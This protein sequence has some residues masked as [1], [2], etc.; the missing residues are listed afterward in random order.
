[1]SLGGAV[2]LWDWKDWGQYRIEDESG[3]SLTVLEYS[4][5]T[6]RANGS[7]H[8]SFDIQIG[9]AGI[10]VLIGFDKALAILSSGNRGG[11]KF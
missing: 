2:L 4:Q 6:F 9:L 10:E 11:V 1:M 7:D 8:C 3:S 5:L